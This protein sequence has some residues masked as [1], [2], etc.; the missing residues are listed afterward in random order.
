MLTGYTAT[1]WSPGGID[2]RCR[3]LSLYAAECVGMSSGARTSVI[4]PCSYKWHDLLH[5]AEFAEKKR[6]TDDSSPTA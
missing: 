4:S 1:R 5:L 6:S 3:Y 2:G